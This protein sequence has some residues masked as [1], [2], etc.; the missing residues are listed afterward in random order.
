[1][2]GNNN[3][4]VPWWFIASLLAIPAL[5]GLALLIDAAVTGGPEKAAACNIKKQMPD[6]GLDFDCDDSSPSR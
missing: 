4:Q 3:N 6:L 2:P 5:S 1:M